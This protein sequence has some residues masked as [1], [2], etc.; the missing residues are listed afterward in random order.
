MRQF[1]RLATRSAAAVVALLAIPSAASA[2]PV[3]VM[4][5]GGRVTLRKEPALPSP[6]STKLPLPPGTAYD[7]RS[8]RP[9]FGAASAASRGSIGAA[10]RSAASGG[11]ITP[12]QRDEYLQVYS[13]ARSTYAR[14]GGRNRAELGDVLANLQ[15]I[16]K[17]GQLTSGRMPA[18]FLILDRNRQWWGSRGAPASGARISFSGSRVVFQYYPGHGLQLQ[19]LANFGN[20]NGLWGAKKY[21]AFR[22]LLDDL[23]ALKATRGSFDTWEYYFPFGGGQPP[24]TSGISQGT[25]LQA[26]ARAG[27]TF[28]DQAYFDAGQAAL[29]AFNTRTPTGVRVPQN[30]GAWYALYSFAPGQYVLNGDLQALIGL[31]DFNDADPGTAAAELFQQGDAATRA[32]LKTCDTGAWSLYQCPGA[33]AD[34][35]YHSL[36]TEFLEK[37]CSRTDAEI[38]CNAADRFKGYLKTPPEI[39]SARFSPAPVKRRKATKIGFNLSKQSMVTL[40]ISAPGGGAVYSNNYRLAYGHRTLGWTAPAKT[41]TYDWTLK[42]VDLAGNRTDEPVTGTIRVR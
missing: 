42:A 27:K 30:E 25:A 40:Q 24:W 41:G 9:R 38:Y 21:D 8:V 31:F 39:A 2:S 34:L 5:D 4:H 11:A 29:G 20:A 3:L 36:T 10:V 33:E 12:D 13:G 6:A 16:A 26:L 22:A 14:L 35:N 28:G 1:I 19:P 15:R 32:K 23:I 18:L 7:A 17:R 37:L